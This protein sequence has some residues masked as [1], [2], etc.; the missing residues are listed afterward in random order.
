MN[1]VVANLNTYF[2]RYNPQ[3]GLAATA[4]ANDIGISVPV[5]RIYIDDYFDEQ[6]Q[7][8]YDSNPNMAIRDMRCIVQNKTAQ[9][10]IA[11]RI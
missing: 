10:L 7:M 2:D 1:G 5:A 4:L 9:E 6:Q 3:R 11:R 8:L